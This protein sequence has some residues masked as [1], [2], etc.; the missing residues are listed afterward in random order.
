MKTAIK[1]WLFSDLSPSIKSHQK[2]KRNGWWWLIRGLLF[3]GIY[4]KWISERY[5]VIL[6]WLMDFC[7][8]IPLI[9]MTWIEFIRYALF[10]FLLFFS[11][12]LLLLLLSL[13]TDRRSLMYTPF[14][15]QYYTNIIHS[16]M[17][18]FNQL[19]RH[20]I[21]CSSSEII[22]LS[23]WHIKNQMRKSPLF[24]SFLISW[25]FDTASLFLMLWTNELIELRERDWTQIE[26]HC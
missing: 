13:V 26:T 5:G 7:T 21:W 11:F 18:K 15:H 9:V 8:S 3:T 16:T 25:I 22:S 20:Q 12:L 10:C 2:A 4:P 19:M 24:C 1:T 17:K 6:W 23:L 14:L